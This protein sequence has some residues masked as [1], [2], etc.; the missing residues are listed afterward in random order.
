MTTLLKDLF[1][2]DKWH[3]KGDDPFGSTTIHIVIFLVMKGSHTTYMMHSKL[4]FNTRVFL[5]MWWVFNTLLF[6]VLRFIGRSLRRPTTFENKL[7]NGI[8]MMV[9]LLMASMDVVS[10]WVCFKSNDTMKLFITNSL[11][12][13]YVLQDTFLLVVVWKS[14]LNILNL[15]SL[16]K[17]ISYTLTPKSQ[18]EPK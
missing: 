17:L 16:N 1:E 18:N 11:V 9:N 14:I 15:E 2:N 3:V 12:T 13:N 4:W 8:S 7:D 6:N 10:L 5:S